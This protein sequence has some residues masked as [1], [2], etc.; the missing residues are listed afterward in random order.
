VAVKYITIGG[1]ELIRPLATEKHSV[2]VPPKISYA[3][4][5][6]F[7]PHNKNKNLAPLKMYFPPRL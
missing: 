4:K 5:E 2:A 1:I 3:Q 6:L 7:K